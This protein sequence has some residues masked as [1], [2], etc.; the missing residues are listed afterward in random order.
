MRGNL[1][2]DGEVSVEDAQIALN[3]YARVLAKADLG[4]TELQFRAADINGDETI[5][6]DDAQL[7]LIY[8]VKNTLANVPTT[9]D[10]LLGVNQPAEKLP[11]VKRIFAIFKEDD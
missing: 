4:L 8:Y 10:D 1:N 11:F 9:W 5:S 2:D 7:I 6:V 3:A